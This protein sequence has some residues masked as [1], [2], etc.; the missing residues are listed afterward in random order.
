MCTGIGYVATVVSIK[1]AIETERG[2]G[3]VTTWYYLIGPEGIVQFMILFGTGFE[4]LPADVGYHSPTLKYEGQIETRCAVM[5]KHGFGDS[6]FYDG[7]SLIAKDL[8]DK[9]MA[10]GED[11]EI[12]WQGLEE[13]YNDTFL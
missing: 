11:P 12:I 9:F 13:F 8:Y 1:R 6:C 7:S 2:N 5:K 3:S 4:P 10:E